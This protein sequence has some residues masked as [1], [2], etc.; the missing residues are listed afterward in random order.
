MKK[1]VSDSTASPTVA[2]YSRWPPPPAD[3]DR[4]AIPTNRNTEEAHQHG[5]LRAGSLPGV[6]QI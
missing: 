6:L 2:S 3:E 4:N 1:V 5:L